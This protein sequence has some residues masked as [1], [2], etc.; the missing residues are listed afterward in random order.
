[1]EVSSIVGVWLAGYIPCRGSH[2]FDE[3]VARDLEKNVGD[4]L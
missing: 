3:D 1:M 2:A 4:K